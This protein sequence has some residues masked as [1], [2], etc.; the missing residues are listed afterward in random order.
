MKKQYSAGNIVLGNWKLVKLIGEG[1]FGKVFEAEREDFGTTY[2]AAIKIIR[3]PQSEAEIISAQAEGMDDDSITAYFRSF[4]EEIVREFALMSKLKGTANVVS[5]EDHTVVAHEDGMGWDIV[6]RMELL[7][8]LLNYSAKNKFSR[9]DVIRVGVDICKAL[10]LCQKFNIMHRDIKP[11]NIFVSDLG[12]YKLGDFGIARTAEKTMSGLSKKGTYTY[13]APEIY[14][15]DAY[16]SGVDIYSLG[17]VLYRLLND[18]RA[19]FLPE[20]PKPITHNEREAALAKRISGVDLPAPKNADGRLAEIVLK[21]CA[22]SPKDRYSSPMQMREELEAITYSS[23]EAAII[24]PMGDAVPQKSLEY[25]DTGKAP[26][27]TAAKSV[28]AAAGVVA[29]AAVASEMASSAAASTDIDK[30]ETLVGATLANADIDKTESLVSVNTTGT[31]F[32]KTEFLSGG[33]GAA[34]SSGAESTDTKEAQK[35]SKKKRVGII[36]VACVVLLAVAL[37][38]A[39]PAILNND[40]PDV[41]NL[42]GYQ[43]AEEYGENED[44]GETEGTENDFDIADYITI[45]G[46]QFSTSLTELELIDMNLTDADIVQLGYMTN[47]TVLRLN[48]NNISNISPLA[49]LTT[50]E[51]LNLSG[52]NISNI[53]P[54]S[55]LTNLMNLSLAYNPVADWH[56]VTHVANVWG[57]PAE[58][59]FVD[60]AQA[61]QAAGYQPVGHTQQAAQGQQAQ[62]VGQNQQ[63]TQTP[64]MNTMPNIV[65]LGEGGAHRILREINL[66]I[67]GMDYEYH[68]TIPVGHIISQNPTQGTPVRPWDSVFIVLSKGRPAT[69][70]TQLVSVPNVI[71]QEREIAINTLE[72]AG[73]VVVIDEAELIPLESGRRGQVVHQRPSDTAELGSTVLIVIGI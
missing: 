35:K 48:N 2:N 46:Q 70:T 38:F 14:R 24:Y 6:I 47:L 10:E 51:S 73:F 41:G 65:G 66:L 1:S 45:A 52:N 13:M 19:P 17:I 9:Q 67:T 44:Y 36:A 32:D 59:A 72:K 4:V 27:G 28:N 8:P 26:N 56:A 50:L 55:G 63:T 58:Y 60:V 37:V 57:R 64:A 21:A 31:D 53:S 69:Q 16:G 5:Y 40:D 68:D 62:Q 29:S 18:N 20:Y 23:E 3:I 22:Y 33:S 43:D 34:V 71:W 54:L 61:D 49:S 25:I 42:I 15:G 39:L 11:E 12:D 7:T 30:T